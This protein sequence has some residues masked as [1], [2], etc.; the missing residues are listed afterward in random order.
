MQCFFFPT[1]CTII[2]FVLLHGRIN[3][4]HIQIY[5]STP[6]Q[7]CIQKCLATQ[8]PHYFFHHFTSTNTEQLYKYAQ[9]VR[10]TFLDCEEPNRINCQTGTGINQFVLPIVYSQSAALE[11][12]TLWHQVKKKDW[13]FIVFPITSLPCFKILMKLSLNIIL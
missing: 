12:E 6:R 1:Q 3:S 7:I 11:G 13:C 9:Y 4:S 5:G 2:S 10:C 8:K